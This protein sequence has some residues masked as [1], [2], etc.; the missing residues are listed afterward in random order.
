VVFRGLTLKKQSF[1]NSNYDIIHTNLS[2]LSYLNL[3]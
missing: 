3:V 1:S 2:A